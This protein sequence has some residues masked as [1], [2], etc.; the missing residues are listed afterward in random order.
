MLKI[1]LNLLYL[2]PNEVKGV[3]TFARCLLNEF[4]SQREIDFH[5]FVSAAATDLEIPD[6]SH[7]HK[8]VV[9]IDNRNRYKRYAWEQLVLPFQ[10]H[11][12]GLDLLHSLSYVGPIWGFGRRI[13]TIHDANSCD[14]K[15]SMGV[16]K[17]VGL[18]TMSKLSAK[19]SHAVTTVSH[20][21]KRQLCSRLLIAEPKI[22]VIYSGCGW[23]T[24]CGD[25][26]QLGE[27]R[28]RYSL[29]GPY[30]VAFGGGYPHKNI[31]ALYDAFDTVSKS[32]P[33]ELVII[34]NPHEDVS[35][36]RISA[37]AGNRVRLLGHVPTMDVGLILQGADLMVFPSLY[38]GFGFPILE[39]Q[40]HSTPVVCSG[41]ASLPEVAGLGAEFFDPCKTSEM[42]EKIRRCLDDPDLRGRL[43]EAGRTNVK[44]FSW[45]ATAEEYINLYR[46]LCTR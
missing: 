15:Q 5:V 9:P 33:H 26:S 43:V 27:M 13:V 32:V 29:H 35:T 10:A 34:G 40:R 28:T 22:R 11:R 39:A 30:I 2:I 21:S 20:F 37:A 23:D 4:A 24:P 31:G 7:F 17:R 38:E 6:V 8:I 12:L 16:S 45:T 14:A 18:R 36:N 44:R 3:E 19:T 46:S 25:E 42:A 41:V 1:G